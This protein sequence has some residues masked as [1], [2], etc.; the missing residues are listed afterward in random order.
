MATVLMATNAIPGHVYPM[1]DIAEHLRS[2][3]HAPYL[4]TGSL[5]R[6]ATERTGVGFLPFGNDVDFDY[7]DLLL[8]PHALARDQLPPDDERM[9]AALRDY[10]PRAIPAHDRE[11]RHWIAQ[12]S[13]QLIIIEN[14][15]YGMLPLLGTPHARPPVLCIGVTP[16]SHSSKDSVFHGP[17]IPPAV[18][19]AAMSREQL[20]G[21]RT[22][23]LVNDVNTC[24]NQAMTDAGYSPMPAFFTDAMILGS[25]SFLQLATTAFEY[26]REDLPPQL[27]FAGPLRPRVKPPLEPPTAVASDGRPIVLVTQGTVANVDLAQLIV[28]AIRAFADQPLHIKVALGWRTAD[29]LDMDIPANTQLIDF[30]DFYYWLSRADALVTNGGYGSIV[31]ALDMGVPL[32]VAGTSEDKRENAARVAWAGC[33]IDLKCTYPAPERL[34]QALRDIL[35]NPL[36]R[37]RAGVVQQHFKDYD[38]LDIIAAKVEA[39]TKEPPTPRISS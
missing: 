19:P 14:V 35:D 29:D 13:P 4:Y 31:R 21:A 16:I 5:F 10:F 1:L 30:D 36:Y 37:L 22:Q 33:G 28:P 11:L 7:R 15:F 8:H 27:D 2:L 20:V 38:A 6:D 18:V 12:L 3:G 34:R 24:F 25:D 26:P 23:A 9:A 17:R 32:I 39:L